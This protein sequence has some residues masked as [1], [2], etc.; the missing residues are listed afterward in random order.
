MKFSGEWKRQNSARRTLVDWLTDN[1]SSIE[2]LGFEKVNQLFDTSFDEFTPNEEL[3]QTVI[4]YFSNLNN[5]NLIF[6]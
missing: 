4:D 1:K 5:Y 6:N 2:N 3:A